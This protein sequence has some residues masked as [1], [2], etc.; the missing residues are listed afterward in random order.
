M[1]ATSPDGPEGTPQ[2][3]HIDVKYS[4]EK[5]SRPFPQDAKFDVKFHVCDF[6]LV[7]KFDVKISAIFVYSISFY[8]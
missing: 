4:W 2:D 1:S 6:S 5:N 8:D 3:V 7:A